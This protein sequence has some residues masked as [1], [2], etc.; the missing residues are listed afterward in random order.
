[1]QH[2]TKKCG[3]EALHVEDWRRCASC[4]CGGVR[5]QARAPRVFSAHAPEA[6]ALRILPW[7]R[8]PSII[9]WPLDGGGRGGGRTTLRVVGEVDV[10]VDAGEGRLPL[11]VLAAAHGILDV[12]ELDEANKFAIAVVPSAARGVADEA[13]EVALENGVGEVGRKLGQEEAGAGR[14]VRRRHCY[15]MGWVRREPARER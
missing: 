8:R 4:M 3:A 7:H 1:M 12:F 5:M 15:R 11:L 6:L 13:A 10:P 2:A 9:T 14:V